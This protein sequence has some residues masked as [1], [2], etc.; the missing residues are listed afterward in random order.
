M[1]IN[2]L[3]QLIHYAYQTFSI[4]LDELYQEIFLFFWQTLFRSGKKTIGDECGSTTTLIKTRIQKGLRLRR[5]L[6]ALLVFLLMSLLIINSYD[7]GPFRI[8]RFGAMAKLNIPDVVTR[9]Y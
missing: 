4:I 3:P 2:L 7:T 1:F 8:I 9:E 6:I 5:W